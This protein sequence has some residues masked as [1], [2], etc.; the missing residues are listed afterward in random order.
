VT[1]GGLALARGL[2]YHRGAM[3]HVSAPPPPPPV[4]PA[5][6]YM[7]MPRIGRDRAE[8]RIRAE[9]CDGAFRPPDAAQA[10]MI[11]GVYAAF[12]PFWRVDIRR[13]DEAQRLAET[14][15]GYLGV[16][17]SQQGPGDAAAAWMVCAQSTFPYEMKHPSSMIPGDA[18][19]LLLHLASLQAGDPDPSYGWD[20]LDAD[21][22]EGAARALATA[23]FRKFSLEA[24][25]A[26]AEVAIHAV[27]FVRYPIWFARYRYKGEVAP[28]RDGV[29]YVGISAV[30]ESCVTA[31]HPSKLAAGA[32]KLRSFFG[33]K[34]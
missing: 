23:S 31:L 32:A 26:N 11:E 17:V 33:L 6:R 34:G 22:E 18:R 12:V 1:R 10:A 7:V 20:A 24:N 15:A 27:H 19:P 29:F 25:F 8:P 2:A 5:E 21:V 4:L 3:N 9:I 28:S 30:D 13:W 14:R 16:P